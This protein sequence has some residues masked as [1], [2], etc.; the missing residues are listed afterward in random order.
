MQS[1]FIKIF[2]WF[3]LVIV[4]VSATLVI[5][6]GVIR[7][8]SSDLER[9][10]QLYSYLVGVRGRRTAELL[11]RDGKPAAEE[12]VA[13]LE[14]IDTGNYVGNKN[15][16]RDF[17][18]DE[19][20]QE[21]IGQ[22]V[23]SQVLDVLPLMDQYALGEPHFFQHERIAAEKIAG[24]HGQ[25]YTFVMPIP[26]PPISHQIYNF[27][28]K[29]VGSE[30]IIYLMA[31]LIVAG[32]FCF[33]LARNITSPIDLLRSAAR[34][35][36]NQ[37]LEARVDKRVLVRR[38]ELAELGS[39]FNRMAE[40]IDALINA[41][42]RLLADVSHQLRSPLTRLN[43]ALGLARQRPNDETAEHLDR[44][45][46]ETDR[47][48][49][50]IG[51]LLTLA[52]VES[53]VDLEQKK[54]FDLGVLVQGVASDGNY[55]AHERNCAVTFTHSSECLVEGA[56]EMLRGAVENVVRN[57]VRH[58]AMGTNVEIAIDCGSSQPGSNAAI[59]VRDHG[60]GVP[61]NDLT[62]L[63]VPFHRGNDGLRKT[64]G[65]GLGLA[66][67]ERA[68]QLHGGRVAAA[69][70]PDGGLIVT[71]ELPMLVKTEEMA[72][73]ELSLAHSS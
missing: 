16:M 24:S 13:S 67:A 20:G 66:I 9:W 29:D 2:L 8:R 68:F 12:Y 36:A 44:I 6:A 14:R 46:L 38:D 54:V 62:H 48:N 69:N 4:A 23:S 52:R 40:R 7:S 72:K 64:D 10:T 45:E 73:I 26:E 21:V 47:L 63:F 39:D 56:F 3:W 31:V 70:A 60:R 37:H 51:Q 59:Q 15:P 57:A 28:S 61:E 19:Y 58:T 1:L 43:L 17:L 33:W 27:L 49:K 30:G 5:S 50:L 65:A 11:D 42:R 25:S 53:G 35:I 32:I 18:F 71:L 34:G 22:Q 55:E 41:Q